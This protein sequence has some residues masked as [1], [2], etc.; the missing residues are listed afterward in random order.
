MQKKVLPL[1]LGLDLVQDEGEV[2]GQVAEA[3]VAEGVG[4]GRLDLFAAVVE[5][6]QNGL[7]QASVLAQIARI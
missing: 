1:R 5:A 6:I 4:C 3:D 2:L 7:L